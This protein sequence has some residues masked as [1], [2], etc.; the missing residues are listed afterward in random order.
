MTDIAATYLDTIAQQLW[1]ALRVTRSVLNHTI[2]IL[3]THQQAARIVRRLRQEAV[4]DTLWQQA[5]QKCRSHNMESNLYGR[6][7]L[8]HETQ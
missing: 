6:S 2:Q 5:E 3:R 7:A 1:E 8:T 4:V